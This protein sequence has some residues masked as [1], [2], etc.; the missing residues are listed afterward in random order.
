MRVVAL[1]PVRGYNRTIHHWTSRRGRTGV[2]N[3]VGALTRRRLLEL[4]GALGLGVAA[5]RPARSATPSAV[6]SKSIR[7]CILVF[8]YGGPSHIDTLV[9]KPAA[10]AE[11]RGE[12]GTI[13]TAVPGVRV[14]EH[15][16]RLARVLDRAALVRSL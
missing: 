16:P 4:G 11:V 10:P 7:S 12:Y 9:P 8:Y 2:I 5:P 14:C 1:I 6:S 15:L 13:S 3:P